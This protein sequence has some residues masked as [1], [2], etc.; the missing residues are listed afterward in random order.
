MASFRGLNHLA[1][2]SGETELKALRDLAYEV[3]KIINQT[4]DRE[5]QPDKVIDKDDHP[6]GHYMKKCLY[7]DT[8]MEQC[9]CISRDKKVIY[10]VCEDCQK[11]NGGKRGGTK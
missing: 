8:V 5:N 9:R 7:C 11:N 3:I 2:Q 4:I 1:I 10:G 6:T